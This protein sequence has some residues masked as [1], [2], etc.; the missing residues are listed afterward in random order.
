MNFDFYHEGLVDRLAESFF[1]ELIDF[2]LFL[3]NQFLDP[4]LLLI[5][6]V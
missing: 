4:L 5:C 6:D 2:F 1:R 3:L